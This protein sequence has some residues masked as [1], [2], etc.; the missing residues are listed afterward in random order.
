MRSLLPTGAKIM[1]LTAT[2]TTKLRMDV[3]KTVGMRNELVV[4][5]SPSKSNIMYMVTK[6]SSIEETFLPIARRLRQEGSRCPRVII[7]CRSYGD[8]A[9]IYL[10]FKVYLGADFTDPPSAPNLPRFRIVDMYMSCTEII[11]KDEIVR[12][13]GMRSSLRV[14]VATIAFGMG[15]DCPDVRQVI[16]FGSPCDIEAYVQETGRAG[17]D[18]LP[19][20]AILVTKASPGRRIEKAMSDY[21]SN[22]TT[23]RRD[24]LFAKFDGYSR[25]FERPLCL[26]C[27]ICLI[28][29]ECSKCSSNHH[30]FIFI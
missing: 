26:C 18:N 12:L 8:C 2:A 16:S 23:C 3:S 15:I 29:C 24:Q 13:F 9:D 22:E 21:A 1:A 20:L 11:V 5:K 7:Y 28:S 14:V 27:D 17:R 30:S 25:T 6:F 19:S 10:Y 4:S